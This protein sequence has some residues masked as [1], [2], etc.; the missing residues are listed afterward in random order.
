MIRGEKTVLRPVDLGDVD[1]LTK[2]LNDPEVTRHLSFY[3]PV[4]RRAEEAWVKNDQPVH[5][6][7]AIETVDGKHIG[8]C[9]LH[10]VADKHR[11][12]GFG[13]FIGDKDYWDG[14]YGTDAVI[15]ALTYGFAHQNL[16][17]I[18]LTVDADNLRA[19]RCYEKAG[20]MQEGVLR[21]HHHDRGRY[22]DIVQMGVLRAEFEEK[23][24][25]RIV[26]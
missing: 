22:L 25:E 2:W 19:R 16:H 24:A 8:N 23:H 11:C 3:L 1:R 17:R 20:F 15:S 7:F 26:S 6:R 5:T 18:H 12:W 9:G 13:I 21:E 14:G 10:G 4:A